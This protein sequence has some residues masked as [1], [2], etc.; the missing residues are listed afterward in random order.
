LL[1]V[2]MSN[3]KPRGVSRPRLFASF[4]DMAKEVASGAGPASRQTNRLL[5]DRIPFAVQLIHGNDGGKVGACGTLEAS[6]YG[7]L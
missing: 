2:T 1:V 4:E 6:R 7:M 3:S 5:N